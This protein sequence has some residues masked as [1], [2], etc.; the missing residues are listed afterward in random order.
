M[1]RNISIELRLF[2]LFAFMSLALIIISL[3]GLV[4]IRS[5]KEGIQVIYSNGFEP[6]S[7][8]YNMREQVESE[9]IPAVSKLQNDFKDK[10]I[11]ISRLKT[12]LDTVF[13]HWDSFLHTPIEED[14]AKVVDKL[15]P[16]LN[17]MNEIQANFNQMDEN[18]LDQFLKKEFLPV[19]NLVLYELSKLID[20]EMETGKREYE[21]AN[22]YSSLVFNVNVLSTILAVLLTAIF[23][24]LLI[25]SVTK[26]LSMVTNA[27]EKIAMGDM[28]VNLE[29]DSYSSDEM[30]R[31][32][33]ATQNMIKFNKDVVEVLTSLSKGDLRTNFNTRN[34]QDVVGNALKNTIEILSST[35]FHVQSETGLLAKS[36]NEILI[37]VNKASLTGLETATAVAET[38]TTVEE[39][40]QTAQI[41][42]EKAKD[43][44][45]S[46]EN[47]SIIVKAS[48]KSLGETME[49]MNQIQEKMKTISESIIKLSEHSL[50]IAEIIETVNDLA[51]QSNLLAV[52]AAIEA[53]KA[54]DQG[55]G[56]S[57]VAQEVRSL[58]E[59]SKEATVQIRAIL[60]DIRNATSW[61]VIATEQGSKAVSGGFQRSFQINK[62]ISSL[63]ASI[64]KIV[65][66]ANQIAFSSQ[67]QL[68]AV[69]QV[70]LAM[71]NIKE[72]SLEHVEHMHQIETALQDLNKVGS[73]L[74]K[75]VG[76]YLLKDHD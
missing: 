53:A 54:G 75:L 5:I 32:Q 25:R 21:K 17:K 10:E 48:E 40:K 50:A 34:Q 16:L 59:Q 61:A 13:L 27:V 22:K 58:A 37:S 7:I 67:Q 46:I 56:F 33:R 64:P 57:V 36:A 71:I 11:F 51:E 76:Q 6:L 66:S 8:V 38:T 30:G 68:V 4:G 23:S 12:S 26:P 15:N 45:A 18:E 35:I 44:L 24:F 28:R 65:H 63:T 47:A 49:D 3:I 29:E 73:S 74:K 72:A 55:K 19:V 1:L 31:L 70:D 43:V 69:K 60:N 52:N 39:L 20:I 42:A 9:I 62:S 14:E 41:S 2:L